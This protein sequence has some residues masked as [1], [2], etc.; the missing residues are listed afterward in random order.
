MRERKPCQARVDNRV[1]FPE[2]PH[3]T[4]TREMNP[5]VYFL[6][7]FCSSRMSRV[8][9][10]SENVKVSDNFV[11]N[12]DANIDVTSSTSS[13]HSRLFTN[14]ARESTQQTLLANTDLH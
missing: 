8:C 11:S 12:S 4:E 14:F 10:L 7:F 1:V 9:T 6:N 2:Q 13:Y 3:S 5:K